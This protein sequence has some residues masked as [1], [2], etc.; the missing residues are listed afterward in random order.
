MRRLNFAEHELTKR[1]A[2]APEKARNSESE[3]GEAVHPGSLPESSPEGDRDV[4]APRD[5][6]DFY[7]S[8][9]PDATDMTIPLE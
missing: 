5:D 6:R 3:E 1:E 9:A 2:K 8:R 7:A 4:L